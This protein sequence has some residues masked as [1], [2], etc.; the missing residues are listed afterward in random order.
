MQ[1]EERVDQALSWIGKVSAKK[2]PYA[3][4]WIVLALSKDE[5]LKDVAPPS[6]AYSERTG[7]IRNQDAPTLR[8]LWQDPSIRAFLLRPEAVI[9]CEQF[10]YVIDE[11]K[12]FRE[13]E[14][15]TNAQHIARRQQEHIWYNRKKN[16]A[17]QE[18]RDRFNELLF[19]PTRPKPLIV[20]L[21]TAP[22]RNRLLS[23]TNPYLSVTQQRLLLLTMPPDTVIYGPEDSG[24]VEFSCRFM[25]GGGS[26]TMKLE[27]PFD[28]MHTFFMDLGD[29]VIYLLF[30]ETVRTYHIIP[31]L[32][33]LLP[34]WLL[35]PHLPSLI[36]EYYT[37]DL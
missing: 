14:L 36:A 31:A 10:L 24:I 12:Q 16:E 8:E 5:R 33:D 18:R 19:S 25:L 23:S 32:H 4:N 27:Q 21:C 13:R 26:L 11:Y 22:D 30:G 6:K 34:V 15:E 37:M 7:K 9:L 3:T 35:L 28:V 17:I 2:Q 1:I 29:R 20:A